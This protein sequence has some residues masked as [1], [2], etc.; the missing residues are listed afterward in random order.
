MIVRMTMVHIPLAQIAD[1]QQRAAA[2][3]V[4]AGSVQLSDRAAL[5]AARAINV[6]SLDRG[7]FG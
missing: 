2:Q 7:P 1:R 4:G 3:K 5:G 6:G